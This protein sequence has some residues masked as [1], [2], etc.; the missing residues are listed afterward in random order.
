L[1]RSIFLGKAGALALL[2]FAASLIPAWH[3][4]RV[5]PILAFPLSFEA[6]RTG[7]RFR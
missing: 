5:D 4:T 7:L 1:N 3:D 2:A 6:A